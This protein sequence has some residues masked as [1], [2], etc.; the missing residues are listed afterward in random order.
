M[1]SGARRKKAG[2]KNFG[3]AGRLQEGHRPI[4]SEALHHPLR[5]QEDGEEAGSPLDMDHVRP[6]RAG[7]Q[8]QGGKIDDDLVDTAGRHE[9]V[10]GISSAIAR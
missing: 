2:K 3:T 7:Q 9:K 1:F 10:S 8:E 5:H 6:Q 4:G